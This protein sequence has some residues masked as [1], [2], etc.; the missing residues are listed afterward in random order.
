MN[1]E[2]VLLVKSLLFLGMLVVTAVSVVGLLWIQHVVGEYF[3]QRRF[4]K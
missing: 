4:R 1:V 3:Y 2:N